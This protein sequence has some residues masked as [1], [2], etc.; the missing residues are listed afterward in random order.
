M[1]P[2][3]FAAKLSTEVLISVEVN[4]NSNITYRIP[5]LGQFPLVSKHLYHAYSIPR[6][7]PSM[8]ILQYNLHIPHCETHCM[9][10]TH[11]LTSS[12]SK[13]NVHYHIGEI[14]APPILAKSSQ[15]GRRSGMI[16]HC[17][18]TN[19]GL[20]LIWP[21]LVPLTTEIEI[22]EGIT[23]PIVYKNQ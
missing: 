2:C 17:N 8:A 18:A 11:I 20:F 7:P 23:R 13:W 15:Q 16:D 10:N 5:T 6:L 3:Q 1:K 9:Y 21:K 4:T 22:S 12:V 14:T 19:A